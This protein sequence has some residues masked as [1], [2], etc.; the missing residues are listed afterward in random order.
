MC[1]VHLLYSLDSFAAQILLIA[2]TMA[3]CNV[4]RRKLPY[5][6]LFIHRLWMKI[7]GN[8]LNVVGKHTVAPFLKKKKKFSSYSVNVTEMS[9]AVVHCDSVADKYVNAQS[10]QPKRL[11]TLA[12]RLTYFLMQIFMLQPSS[13]Q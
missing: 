8:K 3:R 1:R 4:K 6:N 11:Q 12:F 2:C 9:K 13:H 10:E 7:Y 5:H